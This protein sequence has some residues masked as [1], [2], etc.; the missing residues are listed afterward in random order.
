MA[1]SERLAANSEHLQ[2]RDNFD[3]RVKWIN[4]N[5]GILSS[6]T[7]SETLRTSLP[8]YVIENAERNDEEEISIVDSVLARQTQ[9]DGCQ[10]NICL[11][12]PAGYVIIWKKGDD[13][14][15]LGSQIIKKDDLRVKLEET[16]NGNT[17]V[18]SLAEPEDE[19]TYTCQIS[20]NKP[21]ELKHNIKIRGK[22]YLPIS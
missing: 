17:L 9:I 14:V 12:F 13:I 11:S 22:K 4:E 6:K 8:S 7:P 15:A 1:F 21:T 5:E 19:G 18:I 2:S 10:P 3:S 20:A 16:E